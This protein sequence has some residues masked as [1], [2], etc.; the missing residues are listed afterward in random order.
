MYLVTTLLG[1]GQSKYALPD[2]FEDI[3]LLFTETVE[4]H[5]IFHNDD[6][7]P[8]YRGQVLSQRD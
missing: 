6:D 2:I 5:S 3:V 7:Y 4:Q 8:M 1:L